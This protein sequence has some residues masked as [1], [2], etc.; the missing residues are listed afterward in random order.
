MKAISVPQPWASLIV[1]GEQEFLSLE[2]IS[3]PDSIENEIAIYA[4]PR[5]K[6]NA[7]DL[8][9]S[10]EQHIAEILEAHKLT[11]DDL[12]FGA[13]VGSVIVHKV[14]HHAAVATRIPR[15]Q[16]KLIGPSYS[17]PILL[18]LR[19]PKVLKS[20]STATEGKEGRFWDWEPASKSKPTQEQKTADE[21]K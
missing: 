3:N 7:N 13:I 10:R 4:K 15:K 8:T 21:S 9:A 19:E 11:Y 17:H 16:R 20:P 1:L 5:P 14:E 18:V 6:D 12:P 2:S